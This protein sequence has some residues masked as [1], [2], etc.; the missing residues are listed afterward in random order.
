[1]MTFKYW[2]MENEKAYQCLCGEAKLAACKAIP[3]CNDSNLT[4]T[5]FHTYEL[6]KDPNVIKIVV[7]E[8][9]HK[10]KYKEACQLASLGKIHSFYSIEQ[11]VVPLILQDK[12]NVA[13][14]FLDGSTKHQKELVVLLDNILGLN[15]ISQL[16]QLG[17]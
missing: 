12:I 3:Y 2:L 15:D 17:L 11:L 1:M 8:E 16:H 10:K 5:I 9:L 4:L 6:S 14:T 13:E 7:D